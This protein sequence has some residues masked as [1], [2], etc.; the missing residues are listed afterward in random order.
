MTSRMDYEIESPYKTDSPLSYDVEEVELSPRSGRSSPG[1]IR[2]NA[3]DCS[4]QTDDLFDHPQDRVQTM[5]IE[6]ENATSEQQTQTNQRTP[7]EIANLISEQVGKKRQSD[8]RR[9]LD[10]FCN[11]TNEQDTS[12]STHSCQ[13]IRP[14][15][16][17]QNETDVSTPLPNYPTPVRTSPPDDYTTKN[18]RIQNSD[19]Q[20]WIASNPHHIRPNNLRFPYAVTP[21][22]NNRK[23]FFHQSTNEQT[24]TTTVM[25][26]I[27]FQ[28]ED[29]KT[30][31]NPHS[32]NY[33]PLLS[34]RN[35]SEMPF[36]SRDLK[37]VITPLHNLKDCVSEYF[38]PLPSENTNTK[39]RS[40]KLMRRDKLHQTTYPILK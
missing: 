18:N 7:Q 5:R 40:T 38:P 3:F 21:R 22:S 32:S 35:W 14:S 29:P 33:N 11:R 10:S 4:T 1:T 28:E 20:R 27:W 17:T 37:F 26:T 25:E 30:L 36:D 6:L 31:S 24:P 19:Q 2:D 8:T 13:N 15:N 34:Y 39:K 23:S 9:N 16:N 12:T